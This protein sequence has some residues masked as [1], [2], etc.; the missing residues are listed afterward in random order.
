MSTPFEELDRLRHAAD[1]AAM[2]TLV[3][4]KGTT[5]KKA[6]SRMWVGLDGAILGSVTIGGCVD[7]RVVAE[8]ERVLADGGATLLDLS[9]GDEE[10]WEIG[11]TCGGSVEVLIERID[12][13][14]AGAPVVAA[15][16]AARAEVDAG[17]P[18][19]VVAP[20]AGASRRLAVGRE[21]ILAG[22]LGDRALDEAACDA[23]R[24]RL[25]DTASAV[26]EIHT[27]PTSTRCYF[28]LLR[29]PETVVVYGAGEVAMSLAVIARELGM[30]TVVVDGRERYATRERFPHADEIL[31][32]M[33][34]EIAERLAGGASTYAVLVAH[35]YKYDLPVLRHVLRGD[36][37]YI[38]LLGSRR[39]GATIREMLRDEGF[40]DAEL[41]RIHTPIGLAIGAKSAPE[42]ALAIAAEIV[43][44][45][46][47]ARTGRRPEVPA[48][49]G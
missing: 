45:R 38:G 14:A 7:A 12:A 20:L 6:G 1:V 37:G 49:H 9:L 8:S 40:T 33:P 24:S 39:R 21:G 25:E 4:A 27:G 23:A 16:D 29:P 43:A 19:V 15:Y 46:E 35:D 11:L 36:I 17:R 30:R 18:A 48:A 42:I 44:E 3:A 28:E 5:P 2:A 10:A 47:R 32:G 31:V 26:L 41:A 22:S 13:R 34:S